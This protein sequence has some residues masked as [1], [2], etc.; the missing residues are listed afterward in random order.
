[1]KVVSESLVGSVHAYISEYN[2]KRGRLENIALRFSSNSCASL[3]DDRIMRCFV[4]IRRC[5]TSP[6]PISQV[7]YCVT[8]SY[9]TCHISSPN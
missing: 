4:K 8:S 6:N 7:S 1:M 5:I 9:K 3:K 2:T